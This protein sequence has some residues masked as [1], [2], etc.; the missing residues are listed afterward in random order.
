MRLA[1]PIYARTHLLSGHP[2]CAYCVRSNVLH[3]RKQR[4]GR[5]KISNDQLVYE[6]RRCAFGSVGYGVVMGMPWLGHTAEDRR[7]SFFDDPY[8]LTEA[9]LLAACPGSEVSESLYLPRYH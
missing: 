8:K 7:S 3:D 5:G 9:E 1:R 6:C 2:V 4:G